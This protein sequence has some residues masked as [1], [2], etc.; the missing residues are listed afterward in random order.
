VLA[1]S[2]L[3][4]CGCKHYRV[5][6]TDRYQRWWVVILNEWNVCVS[7]DLDEDRRELVKLIAAESMS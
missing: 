7:N 1:R 4:Q 3:Y 2:W 5:E 6:E